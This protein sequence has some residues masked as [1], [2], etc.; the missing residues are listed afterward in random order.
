MKAKHLPPEIILN[1]SGSNIGMPNNALNEFQMFGFFAHPLLSLTPL[2]GMVWAVR[3]ERTLPRERV[4]ET[5]TSRYSATP[6][7]R[8]YAVLR[9]YNDGQREKKHNA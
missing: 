9:L 8:P 6:L 3:L 4:F 5:H 2:A 1:S 7:W